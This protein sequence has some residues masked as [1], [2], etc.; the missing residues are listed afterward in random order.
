MYERILVPLDGSRGSE[1]VPPYAEELAARLGAEIT[2]VSV[3][4]PGADT[5]RFHGSE[6]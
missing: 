1:I 3:S 5:A 2:L 4:E 6:R